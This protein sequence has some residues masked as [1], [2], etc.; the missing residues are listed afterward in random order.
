MKHM[1]F[2]GESEARDCP[3]A[4]YCASKQK[5]DCWDRAAIML[6]AFSVKAK[7][8]LISEKAACPH[9]NIKSDSSFGGRVS[10]DNVSFVDFKSGST[11]CGN[12]QRLFI[13]NPFAA[14][15]TP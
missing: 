9:E 10:Y 1:R 4:G 5:P 6:S 2:Y 11:Y 8:A 14:D 15:Y 3:Y 7:P 13:L 12:Q